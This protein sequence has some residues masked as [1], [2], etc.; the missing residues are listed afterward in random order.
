DQRSGRSSTSKDGQHLETVREFIRSDR[1]P[2]VR[3][4]AEEFGSSKTSFH[5]ILTENLCMQRVAAKFVP[6]LLADEQ[7]QKGL[8]VTRPGFTAV[9]SKQKPGFHNAR[10]NRTFLNNRKIA[11]RTKRLFTL[12]DTARRLNERETCDWCQVTHERHR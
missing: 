10:E 11:V 6:R 4:V 3:E 12:A 5:E 9:M 1:R 2:T 7:K 8:E